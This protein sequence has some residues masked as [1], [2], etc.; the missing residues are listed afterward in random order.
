M[1]YLRLRPARYL[2]SLGGAFAAGAA[3]VALYTTRELNRP[4][5]RTWLDE[6]T[7]SPFELQ[8]PHEPVSF[9]SE[10]GVTLRGWWFPRPETAGVVIAC[11][12][13]R[14]AKHELLGI[15]SALWRAGNNV[16][17][18]DF[19]GC[20]ESDDAPLSAGHRELP[21]ARAAVQFARERLP[22]ARVGMIGYSMGGAVAIAA[23]AAEP[24]VRAVVADSAYASLRE[25]IAH[26]YRARRLPA[27]PFLD[28]SD[29][30]NRWRYGYPFAAL[31]PVDVVGRIAPRPL[32]LIHGG[33]DGLA[34]VEHAHRLYAAA[35]EPKELWIVE[36][37][38]H[39]GAYFADR[40]A[41]VAR[42][43]DFFARAL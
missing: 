17:L 39:C 1:N 27:R 34:P 10:D 30:L 20:G 43:A 5:R 42:V 13:H 25:V 2:L 7:F 11:T 26:A 19:R 4:N 23:A 24:A 16:L 6:F 38:R 3:A 33:A 12:G 36:G 35:G 31:R 18:F 21:D 40:Q 9:R 8:V 29:A 32:L 14:R 28:L 22:G 15:G 41:Y 37:A